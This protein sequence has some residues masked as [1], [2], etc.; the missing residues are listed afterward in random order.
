M[1]CWSLKSGENN[2]GKLK[3]YYNVCGINL[4]HNPISKLKLSFKLNNYSEINVKK[5]NIT[6]IDFDE[7]F[8]KITKMFRDIIK[9]KGL[10]NRHMFNFV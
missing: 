2:I 6:K 4:S 8:I 7:E 3:N 9:D 10:Y 1:E 5:T